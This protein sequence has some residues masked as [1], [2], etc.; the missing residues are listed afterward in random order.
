MSVTLT[1]DETGKWIFSPEV[2]NLYQEALG[3]FTEETEKY[4]TKK[5]AYSLINEAGLS[6]LISRRGLESLTSYHKSHSGILQGDSI[7]YFA[8]HAA[9]L[10]SR[11]D[12]SLVTRLKRLGVHLSLASI[13]LSYSEKERDKELKRRAL[14][15]TSLLLQ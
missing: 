15:F 7:F 9:I 13:L 11:D 6:Y 1:K 2:M 14:D 5:S 3:L 12:E 8:H 4:Q 10:E